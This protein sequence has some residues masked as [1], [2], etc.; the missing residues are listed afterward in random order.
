M[1]GPGDSEHFSKY[2]G[3]EELER[4]EREEE[5]RKVL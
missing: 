1:T 2:R 3:A 4:I 5:S